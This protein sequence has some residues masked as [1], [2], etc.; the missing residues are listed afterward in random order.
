[1]TLVQKKYDKQQKYDKQKKYDRQKKYDKQKEPAKDTEEATCLPRLHE[2]S[3]R[4]CAQSAIAT[5]K[6]RRSLPAIFVTPAT[7]A[8]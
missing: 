6:R 5:P 7:I 8:G 1:M 4:G 3:S 2:R